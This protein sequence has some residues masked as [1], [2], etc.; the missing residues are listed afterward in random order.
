ME[1]ARQRG[2]PLGYVIRLPTIAGGVFT[3]QSYPGPATGQ[4]VIHIDR[5]SGRVLV[6]V[7]FADYGLVSQVTE[8]G[9]AIHTGKQFGL[10][11][12]L[13]VTAGYLA[14]LVMSLA[15]LIMWWKRRPSGGLGAPVMERPSGLSIFAAAAIATG[16][17]FPLLGLSIL[18]VLVID[19]AISPLF[20][21]RLGL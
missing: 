10:V 8:V 15:T 1:T 2:L 9:I 21:R 19:R 20:K 17:L 6:D 3:L 12:L 7:G 13:L 11:N 16:V 18:A 5:Y 4:R 14:I